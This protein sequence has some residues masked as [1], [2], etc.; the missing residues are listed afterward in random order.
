MKTKATSVFF[1]S[2]IV[3]ASS[4]AFAQSNPA[5]EGKADNVEVRKGSRLTLA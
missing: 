5:R 3:L 1:A 2:F 4:A